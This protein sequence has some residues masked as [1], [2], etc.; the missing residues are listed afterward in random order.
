M[1]GLPN[2]P[3]C[4]LDLYL[5]KVFLKLV[6]VVLKFDNDNDYKLNRKNH[7]HPF[8]EP[9]NR[10]SRPYAVVKGGGGAGR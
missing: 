6:T 1:I 5:S 3:E 8:G 7:S 10:I 9:Q 4:C 2:S